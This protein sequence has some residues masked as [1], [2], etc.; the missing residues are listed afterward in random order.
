MRSGFSIVVCGLVGILGAAAPAQGAMLTVYNTL[1]A[2]NAAVGGPLLVQDFSSF[3]V[4]D[5]LSGVPVLPSVTVTTNMTTLQAFNAGNRRM[6]GQGGRA[7]GNA[8]Y[9]IAFGAPYKAFAFDIVAFEADPANPSTAGGPGQLTVSFADLTSQVFAIS[10]NLTG[11]AIFNGL[12]S[13]TAITKVVWAEALEQNGGN[14]E[15]TL[16]NFRVPEL[17]VAVPAAGPLA[18][19]LV[20]SVGGFAVARVRRRRHG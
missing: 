3:A 18:L 20:M 11:A 7:A 14:E 10:G 4:G 5:N 2:F 1:A 16:D 6:F 17:I 9:D 12:V 15:T 8:E 19:I 13:D